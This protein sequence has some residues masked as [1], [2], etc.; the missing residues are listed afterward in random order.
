M[1]SG[2]QHL[3]ARF[4]AFFKARHFDS[5]FDQELRSHLAML[6][7]DNI[8]R[9]MT[10]EQAR[11]AALIRLGSVESTKESHREVRGLPVVDTLLQD[12]RFTVR[13]LRRD[14][15]F[16]IFAILMLALGTGASLAIFGFVDAAL[17][18]PLPYQ[19]PDRL[20]GVYESI[21]MLPRCNLSYPDYIDWKNQN[22]VFS[23][24]D[25]WSGSSY[26]LNAAS[27]T[28]L[29]PGARVSD[30]FF[31]TLG[32]TPVVGRDFY[33]GEDLPGATPTVMLS[34][35]AWQKWFGGSPQIAGKSVTLSGVSY[36]VIGVLPREFYFAPRGR[37]EFWAALGPSDSC[38][39]SRGC[40]NLYGIGRL[41]DGVSV[42]SALA[43]MTLI[44]QDLEKQYP[45]SN[46]GQ[47][48]AVESLKESSVGNVR[49]ILLVLFAAAGLLLLI[50]SVNTANLVLVR[51]ESRRREV[52]VRSS[53]GASPARLVRQFVTEGLVL[54]T[55]GSA[56]GLALGLWA[57]HLLTRLIPTDMIG[58][59]PYLRGLGLNSH[60]V[61][62]AVAISLLSAVLFALI[63]S[64]RLSLSD[65]R[66]GLA[67]GGR[68]SA[69]TMW[70]RFGSNLVVLELAVAVVLLVGAGLL[71]KSF[72]RLL[73]V[74][75]GF[76]PDHLAIVDVA[77]PGARYGKDEQAV[78]LGRQ[79]VSR[80][81][82]LPGV[83][84][85]AISTELPL[86]G[87]GNTT[88]IRVVG[89]PYHGE[90]NEVNER[91]VSSG[92]FTTIRAK[93][94]RGRSFTDGEDASKPP[95]VVIN[96]TMAR[97]YFPD[98]DPIGKRIGDPGLTPGAILE[99]VGVVDDIR[100]GA[101]DERVWPAEYVP[102]NDDPHTSFS[103]VV[104]TSQVE[105][106]LLPTLVAA[107]H[108]IDPDIGTT[109]ESTMTDRVNDSQTAYMHRS[110]AWL[111]GGFAGMAL[112]LGALGLYGVIAYSVSRRRREV[113][114]RMA[115]GARSGSVYWL[116]LKEAGLLTAIGIATG[117]VCSVAA[118]TLL[119]NVLFG[120][121]SWDAPTLITVS[122]VL[123]TS[124][125][126]AS[127]VPARRAASSNPVEALR[128]E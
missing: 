121:S 97:Q 45:D 95:V 69:G 55:A 85:A 21:G 25:V 92:Y 118:A 33:S 5:D 37:A 51:S 2:L 83:S 107:I 125:L 108:Q 74:D 77:A 58:G 15:G 61:G 84:S 73:Q 65:P 18:K 66:E 110:S 3:F 7:E 23:S 9:G 122:G 56:L 117:L 91:S 44:A 119:R 78:A 104:R 16:T 10:P 60:L 75:I 68:G 11:R 24:M 80:L 114:I 59:M 19:N 54:A 40:H 126:I 115:L 62:C 98:E 31:R 128:A 38:A 48:A 64:L 120:V 79:V 100:E 26:L 102:I 39:L 35:A 22:R 93:I 28:A 50:A 113:G 41:K 87:N 4:T 32:I 43:D 17:I 90:H 20:V 71:G 116:I 27:G 86:R 53:L 106:S 94:L 123:A 124:A 81:A 89:R 70:R 42:Q 63:P 127:Y 49:P 29:A 52:A 112:L 103:V 109:G 12:V 6:T 8:G 101:L 96:Q 46:R 105:Q 57:M 67:D 88:W 34:Y 72:Y 47:G 76:Q 30:G 14:A 13:T 82:S 1:L 36:T 111:V 99:I